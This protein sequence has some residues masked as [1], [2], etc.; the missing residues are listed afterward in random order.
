M[1][2][3]ILR[4]NWKYIQYC[5]DKHKMSGNSVQAADKNF[6]E[7]MQQIIAKVLAEQKPELQKLIAETLA[8]QLA[9]AAAEQAA[10][11]AQQA[12]A[13]ANAQLQKQADRI[14]IARRWIAIAWPASARTWS[15]RPPWSGSSTTL[16]MSSALSLCLSQRQCHFSVTDWKKAVTLPTTEWHTFWRRRQPP[17]WLTL[18]GRQRGTHHRWT[19]GE[20][21]VGPTTNTRPWLLIQPTP[22]HHP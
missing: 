1:C 13:V 6:L 11:A 2:W 8:A 22:A 21:W 16:C 5:I 20:G 14:A 18:S 15:S 3:L 17:I 12:A 19:C 10:A 9:A 7:Q 4:S